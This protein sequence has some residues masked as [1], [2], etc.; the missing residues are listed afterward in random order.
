M[1]KFLFAPLVLASCLAIGCS[2][3]EA[4]DVSANVKSALE[5]RGLRDVS[6]S[7]DRAAGVVTLSGNVASEADKAVAAAAAQSAAQ[8]QVVANQIVVTPPGIE[9]QAEDIHDALDDGIDSNVKAL[10]LKMGSPADV[11]YTVKAAVVTLTGS[12]V[13]QAVRGEVE[14]AVAAVPNVKQVVNELQVENQRATTT[15]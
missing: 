8:G 2:T 5:T 4:P 14:K 11:D 3:P 1:T 10:M 15:R 13:S 7:Q 6:V 12:V 9:S